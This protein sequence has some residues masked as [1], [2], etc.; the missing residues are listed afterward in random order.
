MSSFFFSSSV[1]LSCSSYFD[2][3]REVRLMT[4]QVLFCGMLLPVF[5]NIARSILVQILS[6]FFSIRLISVHVV[7]IYSRIDTTAAWKKLR[8]FY[9]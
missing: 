9:R 1:R 5:F 8:L 2:G 4:V 7:Y 6:S 3:F